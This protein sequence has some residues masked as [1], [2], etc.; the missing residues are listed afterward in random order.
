MSEKN[1]PMERTWPAFWKVARI[2]AAAPRRLAGTL[3]MTSEV[4][5]AANRPPPSPLMK[6][7]APNSRSSKSTGISSRPAN[8]AP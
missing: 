7:S 6:I 2:P 1:T 8:E 4:F 5:G 3:D